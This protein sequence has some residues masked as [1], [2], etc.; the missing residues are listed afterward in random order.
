V[1]DVSGAVKCVG[2]WMLINATALVGLFTY[3]LCI[4]FRI[5]E[6]AKVAQKVLPLSDWITDVRTRATDERWLA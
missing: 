3:L 4:V 6:V 2:A 1:E 5:A